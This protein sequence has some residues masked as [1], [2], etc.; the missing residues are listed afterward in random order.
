VA[1]VGLSVNAEDYRHAMIK[2]GATA[3]L[4]KVAGIAQLCDEIILS[5]RSPS[6][7]VC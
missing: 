1:V 7:A 4:S 6:P 5:V 3:M 2:A